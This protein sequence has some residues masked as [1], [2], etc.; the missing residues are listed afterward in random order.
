MESASRRSPNSSNVVTGRSTGSFDERSWKILKL[1]K[2]LMRPSLVS[3]E[4]NEQAEKIKKKR[5]KSKSKRG[6][7]TKKP[8]QTCR[9]SVQHTESK[10]VKQSQSTLKAIEGTSSEVKT[11]TKFPIVYKPT[12]S[13]SHR[14]VVTV[15]PQNTTKSSQDS[16]QF[17][18]FA[19][20]LHHNFKIPKKVQP[21]TTASTSEAA[22][23]VHAKL[24]DE[25]KLSQSGAGS[26]SS[27]SGSEQPGGRQAHICPDVAA[28]FSSEEHES[29]QVIE[30]II[31]LIRKRLSLLLSTDRGG[32]HFV[33]VSVD[34]SD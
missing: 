5:K 17:S 24:S 33:C 21:K 32:L 16:L 12:T 8:H 25:V 6:G 9:D 2:Q 29:N 34:G 19:S 22:E 14:P 15:K 13:V 30:S 20:I 1:D 23:T 26:S 28:G 18:P 11:T 31:H 10:E 3:V 27:S 4:A 7:K